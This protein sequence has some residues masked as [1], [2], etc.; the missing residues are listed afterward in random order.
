MSEIQFW[1]AWLAVHAHQLRQR[2]HDERGEIAQT[3]IIVSILAAAA[4]AI[5]GIIVAKF[6]G[7]A[8]SIPTG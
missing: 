4:I 5:C 7:K 3:V 8:S 1:R 2:R 6:T